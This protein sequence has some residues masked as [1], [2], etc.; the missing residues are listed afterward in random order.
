MLV[1]LQELD[2][3]LGLRLPMDL[4]QQL[5]LTDGSRVSVRIEEGRLIVQPI[6]RLAE[7]LA[8]FTPDDRPGEVDWGPPVGKEVW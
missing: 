4:C 5:G 6:P 2:G 8:G 7:V 1:K 3:Y